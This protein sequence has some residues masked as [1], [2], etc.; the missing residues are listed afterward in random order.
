ME[1]TLEKIEMVK[2]RT[3]VT[4][5]EAKEALEAANGS[6]VDAI[7]DIEE[8]VNDD[9]S[10]GKNA[11]FK[12]NELFDRIKKTAE[13]G[14]MSRIVVKKGDEILLNFPLTVSLIG[15]VIAPWGVIF[16][17]IAA[18]GF[19]CKIEF[20][21]DKGE[22]IDVN[23]KVKKQYGKAKEKS[24]ETLEKIRESELYNDIKEKSSETVDKIKDSE[25]Y[26]DLRDKGQDVLEDLKDRSHDAFDSL[27]QKSSLEE[28]KRKSEELFKRS[29]EQDDL[30]SEEDTILDIDDASEDV[31]EI[32]KEV[33]KENG[34]FEREESNHL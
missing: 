2:D 13:K 11:G 10:E 7:I 29:K 24:S 21:N 6:V 14:H 5:R 16:G 20:I 17:I 9:E 15:A 3:G 12:S 27:K 26:N 8:S 4:Y 1:I 23:G 22:V 33:E 19:N 25:L 30:F 34:F 28:I 32:L 31:D 18:A